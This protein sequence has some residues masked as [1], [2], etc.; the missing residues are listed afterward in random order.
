MNTRWGSTAVLV[1]CAAVLGATL[2]C[3]PNPKTDGE[4]GDQ[5]PAITAPDEDMKALA[6]GIVDGECRA[7]LLSLLLPRPQ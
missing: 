7:K 5:E 2:G 1:T 4:P 3:R 6:D